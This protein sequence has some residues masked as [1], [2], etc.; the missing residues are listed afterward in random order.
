MLRGT[1]ENRSFRAL[2]LN[3]AGVAALCF[4]LLASTIVAV[5]PQA[6]LPSIL[7]P[8]AYAQEGPE[9]E[10]APESEPEEAPESEPEEAPESEVRAEEVNPMSA[11]A[12]LTTLVGEIGITTTQELQQLIAAESSDDLA[13]MAGRSNPQELE[14][15]PGITDSQ[16][17]DAIAGADSF[18]E[19]ADLVAMSVQQM[20]RL[21]ILQQ[22]PAEEPP[23]EE[24]PAEER[25]AEY[26]TTA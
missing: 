23:A 6:N 13:E 1:R 20:V 24:P 9:P 25:P 14:A 4:L 18:Q 7:F 2:T 22:P 3:Y 8:S 19:L 10:E 5:I 26:N 17:V 11:F 21:V 12:T 15:T 16:A